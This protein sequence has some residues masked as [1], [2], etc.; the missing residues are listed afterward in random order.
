MRRLVIKFQGIKITNMFPLNKVINVI[1]LAMRIFSGCFLKIL[2]SFRFYKCYLFFS[3]RVN[4][5]WLFHLGC[6]NILRSD[7]ILHRDLQHSLYHGNS[8]KSHYVL[9]CVLMGS[10]TLRLQKFNSPR[11]YQNI[12]ELTTCCLS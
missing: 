3:F 8:P 7:L 6:T 9:K 11:I 12:L 1:Q 5:K 2:F 10:S 4:I